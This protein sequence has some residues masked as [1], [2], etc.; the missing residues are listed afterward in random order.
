MY[1]YKP[2]ITKTLTS[3]VIIRYEFIINHLELNVALKV[4]V[5]KQSFAFRTFEPYKI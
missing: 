3:K 5:P 2:I 1:D 4:M